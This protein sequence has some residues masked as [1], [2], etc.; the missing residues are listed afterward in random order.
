MGDPLLEA[1]IG[2]ALAYPLKTLLFMLGG[3]LI[4]IGFGMSSILSS[5]V[6]WSHRGLVMLMAGAMISFPGVM[7]MVLT[8]LSG[9]SN[10]EFLPYW[11]MPSVNILVVIVGFILLVYGWIKTPSTNK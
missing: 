1:Q 7:P 2:L 11:F 6:K 9:D 10:N 5:S 3:V 4:L 8:F